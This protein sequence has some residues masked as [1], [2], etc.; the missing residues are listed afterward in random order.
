[1]KSQK[2]K[3]FIDTSPLKS[4]H[5]VRGIG[6]YTQG[7][8]NAFKKQKDVMLVDFQDEA[9]IIHYPCFDLFFTTLPL[10]KIKPTIVTIHDVIPLLYTKYYPL[11]LR[12]K[13]NFAIQRYSLQSVS[14]VIT[15]TECSRK[16]IVRFLGVPQEKVYSVHLAPKFIYRKLVGESWKSEITQRYG[17]LNRFVLYVGDVNYNKNLLRLA[18]ACRAIKTSLVIVGKQAANTNVDFTHPENKF[19]KE[20]MDI[21]GNDPII[22]RIGFVSDE[23]LVKLYNL[24]SVYCQPSLYEGFG[25]PILEAMACGCPVVAAKT[26]AF[27]EI[28]EQTALF[29]NPN[30][31]KDIARGLLTVIAN[32]TLQATLTKKGLQHVKNFTWEKTAQ[33]TFE[34][35]KSIL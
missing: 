35:Y 1:M 11:G 28:S 14:A 12:G 9:Q 17:L 18:A 8:V 26:Q 30:E 4:G 2:L 19:F 27:V 7:L 25:L 21:Y 5:A 32:K 24:A 31:S 20:F 34:V 33:K 22:K 3:I 6:S 10:R 23:D 16:D 15:D 29:V 13:L